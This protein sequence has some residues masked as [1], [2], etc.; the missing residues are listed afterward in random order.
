MGLFKI[1]LILIIIG[2]IMN[3]AKS[4]YFSVHMRNSSQINPGFGQQLGALERLHQQG[5]V[6]K[7]CMQK[8]NRSSWDGAAFSDLVSCLQG[9]AEK[10]AINNLNV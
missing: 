9:N 10:P 3:K 7:E 4:E 5:F 1:I 2:T 6:S 8:A